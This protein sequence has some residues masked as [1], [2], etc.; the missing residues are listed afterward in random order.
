MMNTMREESELVERLLTTDE[1]TKSVHN[2][3]S[4]CAIAIDEFHYV[5]RQSFSTISELVF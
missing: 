4:M 5:V 3:P 2:E 1:T